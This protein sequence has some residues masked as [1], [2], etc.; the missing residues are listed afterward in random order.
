MNNCTKTCRHA[1]MI[2]SNP[3]S[4]NKY[5]F[6]CAQGTIKQTI[7]WNIFSIVYHRLINIIIIVRLRLQRLGNMRNASR[8]FHSAAKEFSVHNRPNQI[9]IISLPSSMH[10]AL[11]KISPETIDSFSPI[12]QTISSIQTFHDFI[13]RRLLRKVARVS[14][15]KL[16]SFLSKVWLKTS[17]RNLVFSPV[18]LKINV[19]QWCQSYL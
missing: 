19:D 4:I 11:L 15:I 14:K 13:N 5:C 6:V 1:L 18:K 17:E 12:S 7:E 16:N 8:I 10:V 3:L 9:W 2:Q